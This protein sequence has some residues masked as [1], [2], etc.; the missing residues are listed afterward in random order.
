MKWIL[1][2]WSGIW[3]SILFLSFLGGF[4]YLFI[5]LFGEY[6]WLAMMALMAIGILYAIRTAGVADPNDENF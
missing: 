4:I 3:Y 5:L 2:H 6:A 1:T